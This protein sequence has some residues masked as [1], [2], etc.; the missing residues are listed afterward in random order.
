VTETSYALSNVT[1]HVLWTAVDRGRGILIFW[2]TAGCKICKGNLVTSRGKGLY[3][4]E[5]RSGGLHEKHAVAAQNSRQPVP[6]L[7][8]YIHSYDSSP[9]RTRYAVSL[10]RVEGLTAE[11]TKVIGFWDVT[12]YSLV[13]VRLHVPTSLY[14]EDGRGKFL[15][16]VGKRLP[17]YT[18]LHPKIQ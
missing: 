6:R 13:D 4:E 3:S 7:S 2:L 17:E 11:T 10:V 9:C 16:N 8:T 1:C 18:A 15:R 14:S 5:F 12:P